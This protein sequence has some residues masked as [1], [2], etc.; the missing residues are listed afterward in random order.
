MPG[1]W[2]APDYYEGQPFGT[3]PTPTHSTLNFSGWYDGS[4]NKVTESTIVTANNKA[5]TAQYSAQ[6]YTVDISNGDWEL[7]DPNTNPDTSAYDGVYRNLRYWNS[8][9]G[10]YVDKLYIDVIGYTSFTVYI[11]SY[12]EVNYSYTVAVKADYDPTSFTDAINN[13]QGATT[14]NNNSTGISA[15][16]AV[17]YTL[18]GG[19]HRICMAYGHK[20]SIKQN[21]DRGYLLIPKQQ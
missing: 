16:T 13:K 15:Y 4:G 8:P 6:S 5:L 19:S 9:P 17:T 21:D 1:G 12:A 20:D 11:R 14:A 2:T 3:L 7:E 10:A 18:D